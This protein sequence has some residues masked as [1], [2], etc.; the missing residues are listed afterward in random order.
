MIVHLSLLKPSVHVLYL[1]LT[2]FM[3]IMSRKHTS[4]VGLSSAEDESIAE[5][6][7]FDDDLCSPCVR[8]SDDDSDDNFD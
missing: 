1:N 2:V 3:G 5:Q 6:D 8:E 4:S 7:M